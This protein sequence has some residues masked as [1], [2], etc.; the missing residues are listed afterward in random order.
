MAD[1]A[2]TSALDIRIAH[3]E[4]ISRDYDRKGTFGGI[5]LGAY[6]Q[7]IADGIRMIRES[8]VHI[9]SDSDVDRT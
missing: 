6:Y 8:S 9:Q 7:G 5:V 3:Y 4:R 1:R 2:N